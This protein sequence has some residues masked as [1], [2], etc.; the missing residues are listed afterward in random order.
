MTAYSMGDDQVAEMD[1]W[2]FSPWGEAEALYGRLRMDKGYGARRMNIALMTQGAVW[3]D[4][5]SKVWSIGEMTD[6]HLDGLMKWIDLWWDKEIRPRLIKHLAD[7]GP[8]SGGA[9]VR[10][11]NTP[12]GHALCVEATAR[13]RKRDDELGSQLEEWLVGFFEKR[14]AFSFTSRRIIAHAL[15]RDLL[16]SGFKLEKK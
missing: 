5:N 4:R 9:Q 14:N 13:A 7:K 15:V 1:A 16:G 12:L 11:Q 2:T 6:G 3:V 10:W 8:G